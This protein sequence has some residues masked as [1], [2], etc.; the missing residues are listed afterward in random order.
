MPLY[1]DY[2][3]IR[4]DDPSLQAELQRLI[5]EMAAA[6]RAR[7]PIQTQHRQAER[8][9]DTGVVSEPEFRAIDSQYIKANNRIAATR[10]KIEEFL[11]R[12]KDYRVD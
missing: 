9:M 2:E 8:D 11:G 6:E 7:E 10:K 5:E 1:T 12:Y 3:R 4:Y